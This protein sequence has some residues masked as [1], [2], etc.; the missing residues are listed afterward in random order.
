MNWRTTTISDLDTL[1]KCAIGN[2]VFGNNYGAVNSV[3]YQKKYNAEI[4]LEGGYFFEK[5][6][7]EGLSY[8]AFPHKL[9]VEANLTE[10]SDSLAESDFEEIKAAVLKLAEEAKKFGGP[11]VFENITATEK[12]TL[13]KIFPQAKVTASPNFADY[14]YRREDLALLPGKKYSKKRNH[15]HQFQNKYS[16][17]SFE[18]LNESNF[19]CVREVE[20]KWLEENA[21]FARSNGTLPDLEAERKIIFYALENFDVFSKSCGMSGGILFVSGEPVA[22]C[23]SSLLSKS[24]TDI[25]FEKCLYSFGRDGGYAII[26]NEFSK[27]VQTEFINREEDLGVE[28]LRKAKLSYYPEQVLEKYL[29]EITFGDCV[30]ASSC[31]PLDCSR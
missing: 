11:L 17:Y 28:G 1:Q 8:F 2:N 14:I 26:N 29:V 18:L 15:M 20:E 23:I 12:D 3:L 27:T 30:H 6:N 19:D 10:Q 16:D 31:I 24:V 7:F 4:S 25:H 21:D 22:F 9:E 5:L 13:V